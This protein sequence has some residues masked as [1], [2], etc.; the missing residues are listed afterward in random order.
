MLVPQQFLPIN[1]HPIF[2]LASSTSFLADTAIF[3]LDLRRGPSNPQIQIL[4][5]EAD[6]FQE[7]NIALE[8]TQAKLLNPKPF[9]V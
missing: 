5:L 7:Q 3:I 1:F 9:K 8:P 4:P 6:L 2:T